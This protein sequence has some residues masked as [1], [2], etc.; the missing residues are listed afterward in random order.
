MCETL[1]DLQANQGG[2][3]S[4]MARK[5][6]P[7]HVL[8]QV[9]APERAV[10]EYMEFVEALKEGC[11]DL[12]GNSARTLVQAKGGSVEKARAV[13]AIVRQHC[14]Q[15][16]ASTF[17]RAAYESVIAETMH[18]AGQRMLGRRCDLPPWH[19]WDM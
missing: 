10:D 12:M 17:T 18:R 3:L 19:K 16:I 2:L 7:M 5:S 15:I 9:P 6:F 4:Y 1:P 13:E 8:N 11:G 14:P